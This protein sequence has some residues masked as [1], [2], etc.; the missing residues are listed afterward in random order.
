MNHAPNAV[1]LDAD[2]P[3]AFL[4]EFLKN[5]RQI[6][7][8]VP[9]SRFLEQRLVDVSGAANARLIVEFG[10]GTGGTTQALLHALPGEAR[11][12]AIEINPRFA[13]HLESIADPRLI[14]HTGSALDIREALAARGLPQP[15]VVLSGIPFST[16]PPAV[17]RAILRAAWDAL[18]PGGRFVAYQFRDSV[19]MLGRDLLGTPEISLALI[20]VPPMRVYCWR[21]PAAGAASADQRRSVTTLQRS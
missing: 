5:P 16:M 8:V 18:A 17:G 20:N 9:S 4:R 12:L 14:V 19:H 21:K 1:R 11:L 15:D 3:L 13:S 2:R 10:P 7:S 6:G